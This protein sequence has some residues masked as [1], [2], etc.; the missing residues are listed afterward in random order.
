MLVAALLGGS[1]CATIAG[2]SRYNAQVSVPKRPNAQ[3]SYN[4]AWVGTGTATV[5]H[6]RNEANRLVFTVREEGCPEQ[7]YQYT[8]RSLRGFALVGT[9]VTWTGLVQGIPIPWGLGVDLLSGAL[10]KPNVDEPGVSKVNYKNFRY[11]LP[12][13]GCGDQTPSRAAPSDGLDTFYLKD[14][15]VLRA[16]MIEQLADGTLKLALPDGTQQTYQMSQIER[17]VRGGR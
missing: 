14:G 4:G 2:G 7:T 9:L 3:I 10:W 12:Y 16:Q 8:S 6:K 1:G 13:A 17:I 5:S 15:T 11:T